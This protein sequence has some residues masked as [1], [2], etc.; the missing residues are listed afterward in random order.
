MTGLTTD[1]QDVA[2]SV[3]WGAPGFTVGVDVQPWSSNLNCTVGNGTF[4]VLARRDNGAYQFL[5]NLLVGSTTDFNSLGGANVFLLP[6]YGPIQISSQ[7]ATCDAFAWD[8]SAAR[9]YTG[10]GLLSRQFSAISTAAYALTVWF[11]TNS[12]PVSNTVPFTWATNDRLVVGN[13]VPGLNR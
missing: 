2:A 7:L 8:D 3:T 9:G 5:F 4:S 11:G 6:A 1:F 12:T 13:V 10:V